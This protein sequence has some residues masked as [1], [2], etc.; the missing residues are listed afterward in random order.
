[1]K[2]RACGTARAYTALGLGAIACFFGYTVTTT[3]YVTAGAWICQPRLWLAPGAAVLLFMQITVCAAALYAL[4]WVGRRL[5]RARA[6][7]RWPR[8]SIP[9]VDLAWHPLSG[10]AQQL[11]IELEDTLWLDGDLAQRVLDWADAADAHP[12]LAGGY[13]DVAS[14]GQW[15]HRCRSALAARDDAVEQGQAMEAVLADWLAVAP[16]SCAS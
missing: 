7:R 14:A 4:A 2:V 9:C 8:R 13:R 12:V 6:R 3:P 11:R 1:M 16:P 10:Q 15:S 5:R